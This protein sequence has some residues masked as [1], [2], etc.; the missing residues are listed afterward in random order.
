MSIILVV[1]IE[2]PL[3]SLLYH[4]L[5]IVYNKSHLP[6]CAG[7][8]AALFLDLLRS[9]SHGAGMYWVQYWG[10]FWRHSADAGSERPFKSV[11][12]ALS[13]G[14]MGEVEKVVWLC[15]DN[16]C[17]YYTRRC[18]VPLFLKTSPL[19]RASWQCLHQMLTQAPA[20]RSNIHCLALGLKISTWMRTLVNSY[21]HMCHRLNAFHSFTGLSVCLL[22]WT[23]DSH[24]HGPRK[25][26]HLQTR[27][28]G[29]RWRRDV[30]PLW[31]FTKSIGCEWQCPHI[32]LSSLLSQCVWECCPQGIAYPTSSQ[33]PRWR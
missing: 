6:E 8:P 20:L 33:W 13:A 28:P 12:P 4:D 29:N 11:V 25:D 5:N 18:I 27:C 24:C 2:V 22:R 30:L 19:T 3:I 32:L 31:H 9:F 1:P 10:H 17:L 23:A 7:G 16:L 21:S 15:G 14:I 26:A